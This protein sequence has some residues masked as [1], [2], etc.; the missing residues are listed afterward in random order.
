MYRNTHP[1]H[2]ET[3]KWVLFAKSLQFKDVNKK[4]R[5]KHLRSST[6]F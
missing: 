2:S 5:R 1:A 6:G 4:E 3:S